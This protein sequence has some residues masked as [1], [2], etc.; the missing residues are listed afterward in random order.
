[1]TGEFR[2]VRSELDEIQ[3]KLAKIDKRTIEDA[4]ATS[5]DVLD[6]KYRVKEL[7]KKMRKLQTV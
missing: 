1:M 3:A 5:Q 6:L 4:D 2:M 7:E